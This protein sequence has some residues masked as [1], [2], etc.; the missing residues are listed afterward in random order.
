MATDGCRGRRPELPLAQPTVLP[1][2]C[3]PVMLEAGS[4]KRVEK[5]VDRT[6]WERRDEGS[7]GLDLDRKRNGER[8]TRES[9][10]ER[11]E[12]RKK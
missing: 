9:R 1:L 5:E 2:L 12:E 4:S 11:S 3:Y 7:S 8:D 6:D 10:R